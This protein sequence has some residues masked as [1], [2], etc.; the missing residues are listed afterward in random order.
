RVRTDGALARREVAK[1]HLI[2]PIERRTETVEIFLVPR[3]RDG[4]KRAAM[5]GTF[6]SDEPIALRLAGGRMI[7]A[8]HLDRAFQRL[9][10]RVLEKHGVGEA[11]GAQ[12]VGKFLS[13]R[14]A[15]EVGNVPNLLRLLGQR[16]D[17]IGMGMSERIDGNPSRKIEIPL[18]IGREQPSALAPLESEIDPRIGWQ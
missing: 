5:E 7:F 17:Q 14:N 2:E 18:T 11:R 4:R 8:R 15:I 12:P 16:L 10:T 3:G 1:G 9:G 13:L 6:E